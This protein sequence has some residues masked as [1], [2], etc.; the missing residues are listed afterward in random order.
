MKKII[1][2]LCLFAALFAVST[3]AAETGKLR[4]VVALKFKATA[5][6]ADIRKVESAFRDLKKKIPQI[7]SLEWG[8]NNSPEKLNKGFTHCFVLSF[9]SEADRAVYLPHPDH[10]AFGQILGPVLEDVFVF[11][12]V[13]KE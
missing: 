6:E 11:D 10:K 8:T 9:K 13:A 5:S 12:Y 7:E 3:P 2:L 1:V 4:H